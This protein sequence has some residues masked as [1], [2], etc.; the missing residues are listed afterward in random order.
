MRFAGLADGVLTVEFDS[1]GMMAKQVLEKK[2]AA[3]ESVLTECFGAPTRIR[4]VNAGA[5]PVQTSAA[6]RDVI[7]QSYDIFGRDKI[8]LTD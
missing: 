2:S 6:A 5:A 3:I 8:E 4:M 1:R 7:Q